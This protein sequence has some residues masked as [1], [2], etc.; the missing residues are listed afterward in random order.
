MR[1]LWLHKT[2]PEKPWANLPIQVPKKA[3]AF[4][5]TALANRKWISDIK[6]ALVLGVF[7]V[8]DP[9]FTLHIVRTFCCF[10][11]TSLLHGVK[12]LEEGTLCL[13]LIFWDIYILFKIKFTI[14]IFAII[15]SLKITPLLL[16]KC[17]SP[18]EVFVLFT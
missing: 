18:S 8:S 2:D 13:A 4:F 16:G 10:N 11:K 5:S 14:L 1:W 6:G 17:G 12:M 3:E 15:I 9:K 7:P